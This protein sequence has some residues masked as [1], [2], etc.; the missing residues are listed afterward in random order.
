MNNL[1]NYVPLVSPFTCTFQYTDNRMY[2]NNT[3]IIGVEYVQSTFTYQDVMVIQK[4]AMSWLPEVN[5]FLTKDDAL[6]DGATVEEKE[7]VAKEKAA[8]AKAE[9]AAK[10]Q[11]TQ[12]LSLSTRGARLVIVDD[13]KIDSS[14]RPLLRIQLE[15][16]RE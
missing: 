7:A 9:L 16:L 8:K 10:P 13:S 15:S 2:N 12:I 3:I 5:R 4:I 11:V 14:H 1:E 6:L